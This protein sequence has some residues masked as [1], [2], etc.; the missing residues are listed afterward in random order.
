MAVHTVVL[1]PGDGIGPEITDAV[2]AVLEAAG[3]QIEWVR[4]QAGI[5]AL[6]ASGEVLPADT[7]EAIEHHGV[8]L[9]GPCT[10][11]VGEGFSSVNV[12]LRKTFDLYAAV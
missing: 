9:K 6:E 5:T 8:A 3:A 7:L 4:R 10:T 12:Q 1:I 2:L 11:P